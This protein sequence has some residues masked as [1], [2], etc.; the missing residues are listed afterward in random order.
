MTSI[1][2]C[3]NRANPP[4]KPTLS[5]I[6]ALEKPKWFF[7]KEQLLF[8]NLISIKKLHLVYEINPFSSWIARGNPKPQQ[9]HLR[10]IMA[11]SK[12]AMQHPPLIISFFGNQ[13]FRWRTNVVSTFLGLSL[14]YDTRLHDIVQTNIFQYHKLCPMSQ[15]HTRLCRQTRPNQNLL[16]A[17]LWNLLRY[18]ISF[19]HK[20]HWLYL[21]RE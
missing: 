10:P 5:T 21:I 16:K 18:L 12:V 4:P 15:W 19:L 20:I 11:I 7:K 3:H 6:K 9:F 17:C 13:L 8:N 1:S 2:F 14:F